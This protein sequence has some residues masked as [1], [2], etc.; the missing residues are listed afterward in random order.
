MSAH[1]ALPIPPLPPSGNTGAEITGGV[2]IDW[3]EFSTRLPLD[4]VRAHFSDGQ[5]DSWLPLEHGAHGYA[6]H[7]LNDR[8]VSLLWDRKR[9]EV[10]VTLDGRAC[11][12]LSERDSLD[13]VGW[14]VRQGDG[15]GFSRLDLQATV[16]YEVVRVE[17]VDAAIRRGEAVTHARRGVRLEGFELQRGRPPVD[18]GR[19]LYLGSKSS[20]R[21]LR[22]Y[23]KGVESA[24]ATPGTRFELQERDA[25]ADMAAE[26]L[27]EA[28]TV[29]DVHLRRLVGFIDFRTGEGM[30]TRRPRAPWYESVVGAIERLPAYPPE[31]E[32]TAEEIAEW[33]RRQG[34]PMMAVLAERGELDVAFLLEDGAS[35]WQAKHHRL[36]HG[37]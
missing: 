35:R 5:A 34:A 6:H 18:E 8:H 27:V 3:I 10:H 20:R 15:A 14:V 19:T 4:A 24:G 1:D 12:L 16:P 21:R 37:A 36:I 25:A 30:V 31:R 17:D 13:L 33:V 2:G 26:Q 32:R 7:E 9:P 28:E 11:R 29:A 22:V 23:D